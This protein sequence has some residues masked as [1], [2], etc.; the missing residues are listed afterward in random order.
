MD[1]PLKAKMQ[2]RIH[3]NNVRIPPKN[4]IF[5]RGIELMKK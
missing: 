2:L 4:P 3:R 5:L 1:A